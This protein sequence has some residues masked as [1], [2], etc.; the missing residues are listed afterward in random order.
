MESNLE[1]NEVTLTMT[2]KKQAVM[3][4]TPQYLFLVHAIS[5][6][7]RSCSFVRS[8]TMNP[9]AI[10]SLNFILDPDEIVMINSYKNEQWWYYSQ[11]K[12][13][14]NAIAD[15]LAHISYDNKE[16]SF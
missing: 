3:S 10:D 16:I 13:S 7:S 8:S 11:F 2:E 15:M 1:K 5:Y 6:L 4:A 14:R 9:H 12:V